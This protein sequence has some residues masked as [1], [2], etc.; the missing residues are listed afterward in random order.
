MLGGC[1][2]LRSRFVEDKLK[3]CEAEPV[4]G[5]RTMPHDGAAVETHFRFV[6]GDGQL[7]PGLDRFVEFEADAGGAEVDAGGQAISVFAVALRH[8][9][10][11]GAGE[12]PAR[13]VSPAVPTA[14]FA[15]AK[16]VLP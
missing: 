5:F 14:R 1:W 11:D 3:P 13:R 4:L 7:G 9:E 12:W 6:H 8:P 16:A 2:I 10:F 15:W